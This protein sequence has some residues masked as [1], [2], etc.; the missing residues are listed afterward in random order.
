M[1]FIVCVFFS[2]LFTGVSVLLC[3]HSPQVWLLR[4]KAGQNTD[5]HEADVGKKDSF[6][7]TKSQYVEVRGA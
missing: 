6:I 2:L 7:L 1:G 5:T 4:V 3:R